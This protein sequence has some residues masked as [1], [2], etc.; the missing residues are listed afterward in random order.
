MYNIVIKSYI[1]VKSHHLYTINTTQITTATHHSAYTNYNYYNCY[2]PFRNY[3]NRLI[4]QHFATHDCSVIQAIIAV[5]NS[6]L[7]Q[8]LYLH[9]H[10]A[11]STKL[12]A[13]TQVKY[14]YSHSQTSTILLFILLC[15]S[16]RFCE[17]LVRYMQFDIIK[18]TTLLKAES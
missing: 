16:F 5:E 4:L 2:N 1:Y 15:D 18:T 11:W 14:H 10:R 9:F 8:Y 6:Y 3:N 12:K 17:L 7:M 13:T